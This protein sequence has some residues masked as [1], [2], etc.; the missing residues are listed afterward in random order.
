MGK[1]LAAP[2][3]Q[4]P[5]SAAVTARGDTRTARKSIPRK[6]AIP[7]FVHRLTFHLL[8]F[9][10]WKT[11]STPRLPA[12]GLPAS[13]LATMKSVNNQAS[14][15]NFLRPI[16]G[17]HSYFPSD[18]LRRVQSKPFFITCQVPTLPVCDAVKNLS[19]SFLGA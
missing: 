15:L 9:A 14:L 7:G 3:P 2:A 13:S 18:I 4:D 16:K 8:G 10:E 17:T 12:V 11:K 19:P 5:F 1:P 6:T